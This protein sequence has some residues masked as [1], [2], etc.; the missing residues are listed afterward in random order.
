[1]IL[2]GQLLAVFMANAGGA[3]DNAKKLI[4]DEPRDLA[5]NTG[6]GSERHKAAYTTAVDCQ[7]QSLIRVFR[8]QDWIV[9]FSHNAGRAAEIK[10]LD[11]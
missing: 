4:E 2:V 8:F 10:L 11:R 9:R 6:K 7:E 5:K 1:M 3:W